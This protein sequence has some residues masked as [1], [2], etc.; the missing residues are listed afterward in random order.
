MA[1]E[2]KGFRGTMSIAHDRFIPGLARLAKAIKETGPWRP[3]RSS[4]AGGKAALT[5]ITA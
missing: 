1:G 4:T 5:S 2:G 3:V